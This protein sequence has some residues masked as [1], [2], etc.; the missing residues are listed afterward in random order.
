MRA[1][2]FLRL[3]RSGCRRSSWSG[4]PLCRQARAPAYRARDGCAAACRRTAIRRSSRAPCSWAA[5]LSAV[6]AIGSRSSAHRV[7]R[8]RSRADFCYARA[9]GAAR[10]APIPRPSHRSDS[11]PRCARSCSGSLQS[12]CQPP[13]NHLVGATESQQIHWT[14]LSSGL[15]LSE[16]EPLL[17]RALAID[18]SLGPDHPDVARDRNNLALLLQNTH[19]PE[20]AEWQMRRALA[21]DEKSLG[22]KHPNVARD[23]D[24]LALLLQERDDW[25]GSLA[26]HR[27]AK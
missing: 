11:A 1:P 12:T 22:A 9:A 25:I 18:E 4:W 2:L 23:L 21:I 20:E 7:W 26:F 17:R 8:S 27:R 5:S 10:S 6:G 16:A 24:N 14:Q 13:A 19:R 3:S 15:T